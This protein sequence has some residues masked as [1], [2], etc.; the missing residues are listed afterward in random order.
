[1]KTP[2][3]TTALYA[4]LI[5]FLIIVGGLRINHQLSGENW[6]RLFSLVLVLGNLVRLLPRAQAKKV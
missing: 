2:R 5:A 6:W 4:L 1:M 3:L